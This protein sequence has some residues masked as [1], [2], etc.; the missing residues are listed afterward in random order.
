MQTQLREDAERFII[1][2]R[3]FPLGE[4]LR[5]VW[6]PQAS[7]PS[8][9]RCLAVLVLISAPSDFLFSFILCGFEPPFVSL[10]LKSVVFL[11]FF[12]FVI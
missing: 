3:F 11:S 5:S 7:P 2:F 4:H 6:A 9:I 1:S 12:S 8:A 10:T